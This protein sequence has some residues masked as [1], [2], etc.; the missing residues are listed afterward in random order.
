MINSTVIKNDDLNIYG[1][2]KK[3]NHIRL[4]N[5]SIYRTRCSSCTFKD[6]CAANY[7]IRGDLNFLST[8]KEMVA[9]LPVA[10]SLEDEG[11]LL[12]S[13]KAK[14]YRLRK[15]YINNDFV[16]I[17]N[18]WIKVGRDLGAAEQ[19]TAKRIAEKRNREKGNS[20]KGGTS[21]S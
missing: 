21:I 17:S 5:N 1:Y 12:I 15:S 9:Q 7:V 20:K 16:S 6:D 13:I 2:Q 4:D 18:D 8:K 14:M 10:F 11:D 19:I 3:S